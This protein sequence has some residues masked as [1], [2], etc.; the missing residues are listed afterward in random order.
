MQP[1]QYRSIYAVISVTR[2]LSVSPETGE[3]RP[4]HQL[5]LSPIILPA[6]RVAR[7][8]PT[9]NHDALV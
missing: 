4:F 5:Q 9:N 2:D 8:R 7:A 3:A 1:V 6:A